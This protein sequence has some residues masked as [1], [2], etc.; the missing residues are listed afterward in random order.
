M[1]A[2]DGD[3]VDSDNGMD[4][5][6]ERSGKTERNVRTEDTLCYVTYIEILGLLIKR[7]EQLDDPDGKYN[8]IHP[9]VV[10]RVGASAP[11]LVMML[12]EIMD[13]NVKYPLAIKRG[14]NYLK[15][16]ED[17]EVYNSQLDIVVL[18][19]A[20]GEVSFN[21]VAEDIDRCPDAANQVIKDD[22]AAIS[23]LR[24]RLTRHV[25]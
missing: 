11:I 12:A 21:S 10:A 7:K 8:E 14:D 5:N 18:M 6:I 19:N 16:H 1:E 3:I 22:I 13:K 20:R 17:L 24:K 23:D 2:E 4:I 25:V 9:S 15:I